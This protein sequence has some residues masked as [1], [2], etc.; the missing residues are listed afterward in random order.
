M[1]EFNVEPNDATMKKFCQIC[2]CKN[3]A[4]DKNC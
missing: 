3:I 2:G 4:K 1:G